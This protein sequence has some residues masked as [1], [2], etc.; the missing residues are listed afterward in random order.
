[1]KKRG[2]K[3][4]FTKEMD[5]FILK[6]DAYPTWAAF[7]NEFKRRFARF[8][9]DDVV[10]ALTMDRLKLKIKNRYQILKRSQND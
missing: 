1:M 10:S 2:N 4:H 7:A 5:E 9:N 8:A 6:V 3:T